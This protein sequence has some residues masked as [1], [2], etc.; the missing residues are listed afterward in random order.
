LFKWSEKTVE[1][2]GTAVDIVVE[3][4]HYLART[5]RHAPVAGLG[6]ASIVLE[7]LE[8]SGRPLAAQTGSSVVGR[9]VV[10]HDHVVG[11]RL[12][13]QVTQATVGQL[14]PVVGDDHRID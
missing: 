12:T 6:K 3:Q 11:N 7:V 4:H 14:I 5:R 2:I 1:E 8:M 9:S 10:N 13:T